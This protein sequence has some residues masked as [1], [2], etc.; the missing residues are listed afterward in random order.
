MQKPLILALAT[1]MLAGCGLSSPNTPLV[2]KTA[3]VSSSSAQGIRDGVIVL[4][5][6]RFQRLDWKIMD[7]VLTPDE[8]ED[9][10]LVIPGIISGFGDYDADQD[11]KITLEEFLRD[12]V[13]ENWIDAVSPKLQEQFSSLDANHDGVLKGS[14]RKRLNLFFMLYPEQNGGDL[15]HDDIVSISEYEDAYMAVLPSM[16][17]GK[18]SASKNSA[19]PVIVIK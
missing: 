17:P 13:I 4:R 2:T 6:Q 7:G 11:G 14:E 3:K 8:V 12:D 18:N 15:N 9:S 1:L 10:A 19:L 16:Q 5:K